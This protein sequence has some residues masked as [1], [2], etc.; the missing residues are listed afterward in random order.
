MIKPELEKV[1]LKVG[2]DVYLS[3]SP[4]RIDPGNKKYDVTRIPKVVGGLTPAGGELTRILYETI[5]NKVHLV[6]SA[7]AAEM[8]NR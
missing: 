1:G 7:D 3:F 6:S 5:I 8:T 4:E 2:R